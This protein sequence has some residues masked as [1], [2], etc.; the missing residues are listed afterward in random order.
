L[1]QPIHVTQVIQ[2]PTLAS[3]QI[4]QFEIVNIVK[5]SEGVKVEEPPSEAEIKNWASLSIIFA[6]YV[7][8]NL[9]T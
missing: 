8:K 2:Q 9:Q 6:D 1:F 3:S 5:M 4:G 7:L